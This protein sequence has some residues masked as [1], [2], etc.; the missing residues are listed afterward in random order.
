MGR[1]FFKNYMVKNPKSQ[2]SQ[3]QKRRGSDS[4]MPQGGAG[5]IRFYQD[6]SNGIKVS[7]ITVLV[8][9][10]LL[11]VIVLLAHQGLL[12]IIFK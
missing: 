3:R 2:S 5:L 4:P 12:D 8:L 11:I 6:Q 7:P 1:W 9:S 10:S